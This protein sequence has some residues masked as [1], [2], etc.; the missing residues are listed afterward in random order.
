MGERLILPP[1]PPLWRSI[2]VGSM[3]CLNIDQQAMTQDLAAYY[4]AALIYF[5]VFTK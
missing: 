5:F 2:G 4:F 1:L 3:L